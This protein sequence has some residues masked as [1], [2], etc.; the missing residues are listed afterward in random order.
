MAGRSG[1]MARE[2]YRPSAFPR[3][4]E[5][6]NPPASLILSRPAGPCRRTHGGAAP[7]GRTAASFD[8]GA[9][10]PAQD[11]GGWSG[12][13]PSWAGRSGDM[14]REGY[15]PSAFPRSIE[16]SNPSRL[17]HPEQARRAVSKDARRCRLPRG[18]RLR[19]ST[20]ALRALLRMREGGAADRHH[21]RPVGRH[22]ARG[23]STVCFPKIDRKVEPSRLPHPE[24]AR[25]AVSKDARRCRPR[26]ED[27]CVLRHG[28]C[29]PCSG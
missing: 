4:I 5:R 2:G 23:L 26:R 10:R 21:G 27:G 14:A 9:A 11:E 8:T 22:G 29:A 1:D 17:P 13:S 28:R 15:R 19:P 24:Q 25:R 16:R 7:A 3:S 20:R 12:G 6:S 18:G